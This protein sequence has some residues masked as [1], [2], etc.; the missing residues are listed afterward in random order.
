MKGFKEHISTSPEDI[1]ESYAIS[2]GYKE[3]KKAIEHVEMVGQPNSRLAK[4][5]AKALGKGYID[6]FKKIQDHMNEIMSIWQDIEQDV[7]SQN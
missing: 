4:S 5:I 6:D 1:N 3:F 7:E 2:A